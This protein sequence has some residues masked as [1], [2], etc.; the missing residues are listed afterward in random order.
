MSI[1]WL[2]KLNL[3]T[4]LITSSA[5]GLS[6]KDD[7]NVL[8]LKFEDMKQEPLAAVEQIATFL[9]Y[10]SLS[11]DVLRTIVEKT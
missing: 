1:S 5:G 4:T 9:G 7:V 2:G 10:A 6:H 8:F 11:Q 3:E